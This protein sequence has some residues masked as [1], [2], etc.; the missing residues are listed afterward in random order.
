MSNVISWRTKKTPNGFEFLVV[1]LA[2][3][4]KTEILKTGVLPTR[5]R[6]VARAKKWVRHLKSQESQ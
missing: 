1:E 2:Y 5:A 6:A 3:Q 4:V